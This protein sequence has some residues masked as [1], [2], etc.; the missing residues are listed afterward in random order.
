MS[1]IGTVLRDRYE[2]ITELGKGGMSTVY[3]AKDRNLDSYWAVKQVK[4]SSS[5]E[6]DAF[7]KEVELLSSLSHSDIPRIVDRIEVNDDFYVVMDFVD[8]TSLGKKVLAEG[9]LPEE[10]VVE[11]AKMLCD[12]IDY[13]HHAKANPIIYRDMKPDNVMLTQSGRIKLIDFGIAKEIRHGEKQTGASVGTRGY[14]APEQYRGASNL[15]DERTDIYSLGATLYYLVTGYTPGK[16]PKAFRPVRQINP[17]LSEGF[18]YIVAKCT[19]DEPG[20]RYQNCKEIKDDLNHIQQLSGAYRSKMNKRLLSFA[21]SL[22]LAVIFGVI[23]IIGY[24]GMQT[25]TED[26]FQT[27]FQLASSYDRKDDYI[28]ASKYYFEAIQYKPTDENTYLLLFNSLLPH[29]TDS[30][31]AAI[32]KTAVDD[33]RNR[34]LDNENSPMYHNS[35]LMYQAAQRCLEVNDSA[36]AQIAA[37]YIQIIKGSSDYLD[38]LMNANNLEYY[39]IIATNRAKDIS[40]QDFIAFGKALTDLENAT[41]TENYSADEKLENYY[42]IMIMYNTYPNNLDKAYDHISQ[43]GTKSKK[44]IDSNS[45]AEDM[46]FNNI[47][48]MYELVASSLYNSAVTMTDVEQ[49]KTAY[50]S[51]L[52]WFDAL[53]DIDDDLTETLELKKGNAYKGIFELYNT[54]EQQDKIDSSISA[55]LDSAIGVYNH[56]ISKNASS[57][58]AHVYLTQALLDKETVKASENRDFTQALAVYDEV[59]TLKNNDKNLSNI[60]LSQFSSLKQQMQNAG[61]EG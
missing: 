9:P 49:K 1:A 2:L 42:S 17:L 3:L 36:Y 22:L 18:E 12:V 59:V 56:V 20:D 30:D 15:L 33:I 27:T 39:D 24:N 21:G 31:F 29:T 32:T 55:N 53:A 40:T 6:I 34:Y 19:M 5:V 50:L 25:D 60:A 37:D 10:H 58:L 43:L 4:N 52:S 14:A 13:L 51:S 41:D 8:G 61:L 54:V 46:K 45:N 23:A 7:K 11:W 44:I 38:G 28:N 16:P 35:M 26:K 47:I 57:F 48:P